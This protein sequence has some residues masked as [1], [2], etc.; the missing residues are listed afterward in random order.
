M[1]I[2]KEWDEYLLRDDTE[3]RTGVEYFKDQEEAYSLF[4]KTPFRRIQV[5]AGPKD[6]AILEADALV[7]HIA[8]GNNA[9]LHN[10]NE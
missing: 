8:L 6:W 2:V 9:K 3:I 1:K 10:D 5:F 7:R 4:S